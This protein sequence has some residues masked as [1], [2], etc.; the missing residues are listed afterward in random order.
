MSL[1]RPVMRQVLAHSQEPRR[2]QLDWL[3]ALKERAHDVRSQ[4]GQSN[5]RSKVALAYSEAF[6]HCLDAVLRSRQQ[7]FLDRE[8]FFNQFD[9]AGVDLSLGAILDH[10]AFPLAGAPQGSLDRH[11]EGIEIGPLTPSFR[12][13]RRGDLNP[14]QA[15]FDQIGRNGYALN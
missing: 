10:E 3:T 7:L 13:Q 4:I 15:D 12:P 8:S 9:E 5:K 11:D 14:A 2:R 1:F 6:G